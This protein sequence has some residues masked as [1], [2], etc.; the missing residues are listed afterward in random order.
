MPLVLV[1]N[2]A[3]KL[4]APDSS[5]ALP[6]APAMEVI[7]ACNVVM[8]YITSVNDCVAVRYIG[9]ETDAARPVLFSELKRT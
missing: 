3:Q 2:V 5:A 1:A 4:R 9:S 7:C 8:V 6:V